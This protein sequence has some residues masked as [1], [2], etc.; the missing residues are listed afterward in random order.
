KR[1]NPYRGA[2]SCPSSLYSEKE[3]SLEPVSNVRPRQIAIILS[4]SEGRQNSAYRYKTKN[5]KNP[6]AREDFLWRTC[7]FIS[8]ML[9]WSC[10]CESDLTFIV[11]NISAAKPRSRFVLGGVLFMFF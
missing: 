10:E 1:L 7:F 4:E 6:L 2:R 11:N 8:S 3:E 9:Y 5:M